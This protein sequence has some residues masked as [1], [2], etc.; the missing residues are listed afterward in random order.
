MQTGCAGAGELLGRPHLGPTQENRQAREHTDQS[1]AGRFGHGSQGCSPVI[2]NVLVSGWGAAD[3][4]EAIVTRAIA[5]KIKTYRVVVGKSQSIAVEERI[6]GG[7][8]DIVKYQIGAVGNPNAWHAGCAA[9]DQG[10]GQA[11]KAVGPLIGP[12]GDI[13]IS[14]DGDIANYV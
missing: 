4:K 7:V 13:Q 6:G 8:D 10:R 5:P 3:I 14:A 9:S 1:D 12:A 2:L 11:H